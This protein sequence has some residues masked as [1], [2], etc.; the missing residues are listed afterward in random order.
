MGRH[1]TDADD[2]SE[3]ETPPRQPVDGVR[4]LRLPRDAPRELTEMARDLA[5][6]VPVSFTFN[7]MAHA[8]MMATPLD[9]ED[10]AVGFALT[11]KIVESPGEIREIEL[12]DAPERFKAL[13]GR[14]RNVVGQTGCGLCG[15]IELEQALLPL[16]PVPPGTRIEAGVIFDALAGLAAR[17]PLQRATGAMHAA[18]FFTADGALLH[19]RED[20]GRHNAFDKVIGALAR[21]DQSP[22]TGF[23]VLTSRCSYELVE[24]AVLARIPIL[25]TISAPT[26][27]A[28]ERAREAGLTLVSLARSDSALV[29][30]DPA[31]R[32]RAGEMAEDRV[33]AR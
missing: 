2:S 8:V 4:V 11:Q 24:K 12:H 28:V 7:G 14:R 1:M 22:E 31:G 6:E 3:A 10:F 23:A 25:V 5:V 20:V 33:T 30:N 27:L 9:L 21:A 16:T 13:T 32:V 19:L 29:M 18:G 26:S 15:I 17:Q